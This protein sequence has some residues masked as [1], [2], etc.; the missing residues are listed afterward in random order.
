[1]ISLPIVCGLSFVLRIILNGETLHIIVRT[2][3]VPVSS[4]HA[5]QTRYSSPR[6]PA[7]NGDEAPNDLETLRREFLRHRKQPGGRKDQRSWERSYDDGPS[8]CLTALGVN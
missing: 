8:R 7:D 2:P 3:G 1:M 5:R 6:C 4:S